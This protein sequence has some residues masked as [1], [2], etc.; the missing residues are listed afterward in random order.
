MAHT[1]AVGA[2]QLFAISDSVDGTSGG[3]G[4]YASVHLRDQSGE[5][6]PRIPVDPWL[7]EP[8]FGGPHPRLGSG[9]AVNVCGA[10]AEKRGYD[11]EYRMVASDGRVVWLRDL[12]SVVVEN[13]QATRL[14]GVMVDITARKQA[15]NVL[16]E[17][18]SLLDLTHDTIFVRDMNDVI[19]FWNRGASELYGW[20][21]AEA[22][23][24]VSH[25]LTQ[26][27]FPAPLEQITSELL[28]EGRWEGELVHTKR[29]GSR[30]VVASRWR[31]R[32][33]D[34]AHRDPGTNQRHHGAS[35]PG[36]AAATKSSL[37][38]SG[39]HTGAGSGISSK[40]RSPRR[41]VAAYQWLPGRPEVAPYLLHSECIPT[42]AAGSTMCLPEARTGARTSSSKI[43]SCCP[44]VQSDTYTPLAIR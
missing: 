6:S 36:Q 22:V 40:E 9:D 12:V 3:G 39:R 14:R 8:A 32:D 7:Y 31:E 23:G 34:A 11:F 35:A 15:E 24:Q 33:S 27:V 4:A 17:Q 2:Q 41:R 19:R 37:R 43:E 1:A 38:G 29:D 25:R 42:T 44:A 18:A 5:K 28:Q 21:S 30:V 26:T 10:T 13:D 20:T 16:K